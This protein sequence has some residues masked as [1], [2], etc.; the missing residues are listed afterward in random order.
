MDLAKGDDSGDKDNSHESGHEELKIAD[1]A[2]L[3]SRRVKE[4]DEEGVEYSKNASRIE[5]KV[6]NEKIPGKGSADDCTNVCAN[7][8][9][10]CDG[11][12]DQFRPTR[13]VLVVHLG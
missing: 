11:I 1:V 3:A 12:N 10:L 9:C 8:G 5:R 4:Q 2:E 13:H 6:G 7:V